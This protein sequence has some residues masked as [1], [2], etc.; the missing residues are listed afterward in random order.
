MNWLKHNLNYYKVKQKIGIQ[1][2]DQGYRDRKW[3]WEEDLFKIKRAETRR[4]IE[5]LGRRRKQ[6]KLKGANKNEFFM[7]EFPFNHDDIHAVLACAGNPAYLSMQNDSNEVE[8]DRK[9]WDS[10]TRD[11]KMNCLVEE[12]S[13]LCVERALIIKVLR[14][15]Y[16]QTFIDRR[17]GTGTHLK[18]LGWKF[19]HEYPSFRW[20]DGAMSYHRM[21]FPGSTGYNHGMAKIW[22]CGQAKWVLPTTDVI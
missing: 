22:D 17:Y 15:T 18:S 3:S 16:I 9:L 20:T 19:V 21:K 4:I 2:I 5:S 8:F 13:V 14:P 12:L 11:N 1:E 6:S 10:S 7:D